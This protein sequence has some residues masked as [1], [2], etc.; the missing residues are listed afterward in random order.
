LDEDDDIHGAPAAAAVRTKGKM[1]TP[2]LHLVASEPPP[3]TSLTTPTISPTTMSSD[4]ANF[5]PSDRALGR[6]CHE[7]GS[8]QGD[9]R[10]IFVGGLP[11]TTNSEGLRRYFGKHGEIQNAFI[12]SDR[13]SG[14]SRGF[15]FVKFGT[16]EA[17][18]S[19]LG[20]LNPTIEGRRVFCDLA[21]PI[22]VES[23]HQSS[24]PQLWRRGGAE[25]Y[26][27]Q[28]RKESIET[29]G[30][31]RRLNQKRRLEI[32]RR[33]E[34]EEKQGAI[35]RKL[36]WQSEEERERLARDIKRR[37]FVTE[38]N[39]HLDADHET[40]EEQLEKRVFNKLDTS[41]DQVGVPIQTVGGRK[42]EWGCVS[43]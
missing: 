41:A 29:E 33:I 11:W 19:A 39:P 15:G 9:L 4:P 14:K 36:G 16:S 38:S 1:K 34:K 5:L 35:L 26:E 25:S 23:S 24:A 22:R 37:L 8:P 10:T 32:R 18:H 28:S 12:I 7:G 31:T 17:G 30:G 40:G 6:I 13:E 21:R 43:N 2:R 20:E 3:A 27:Q 42:S